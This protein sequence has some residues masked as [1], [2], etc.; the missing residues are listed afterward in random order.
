M[1][2]EQFDDLAVGDVVQVDPA[3]DERFGACFLVVT[4]LKSWGVQGYV[5]VP[6][7]GDAYYRVEYAHV[8]PIGKAEWI[9][10]RHQ[11]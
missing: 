11:A 8:H 2:R 1:T 9:H 7:E 10:E 5:R 6:G 3:H 4:E